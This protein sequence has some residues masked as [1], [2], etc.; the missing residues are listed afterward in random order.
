M[1]KVIEYLD[2]MHDQKILNNA[3]TEI[4][5]SEHFNAF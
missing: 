3:S 2:S 5:K 4:H 1:R